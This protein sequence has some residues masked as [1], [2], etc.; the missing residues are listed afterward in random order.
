MDLNLLVTKKVNRG[1]SD[2]L[3]Y[4][5][6][7]LPTDVGNYTKYST[8]AK[9]LLM[10]VVNGLENMKIQVEALYQAKLQ[11]NIDSQTKEQNLAIETRQNFLQTASDSND[12]KEKFEE[13]IA[14][15]ESQLAKFNTSTDSTTQ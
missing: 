7:E 3:A 1:E 12:M 14:D 4:Y 10:E 6:Y 11:A 5:Y 13:K 9:P 15:L 8:Q 2:Q